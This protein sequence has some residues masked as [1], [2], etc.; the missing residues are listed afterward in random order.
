M[1]G[2][3]AQMEMTSGTRSANAKPNAS[4]PRAQASEK[5]YARPREEAVP[6][7]AARTCDGCG[8]CA[9]SPLLCRALG[10][11]CVLCFT[12]EDLRLA[13]LELDRDSAAAQR[14]AEAGWRLRRVWCSALF[15]QAF[16]AEPA[17]VSVDLLATAG[18]PL[19][20][21][22]SFRSEGESGCPVPSI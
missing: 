19:T 5:N 21:L 9:P 6:L 17:L 7:S 14:V 3:K 18:Q 12:L 15:D 16:E 13:C 10:G 2:G 20:A 11:R 1:S 22:P 8:R 4:S